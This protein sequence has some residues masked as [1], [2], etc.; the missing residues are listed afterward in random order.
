MPR[1]IYM[2]F[3][4]WV[5]NR[6]MYADG[7]YNSLIHDKDGHIP[8]PLLMFTCTA[9]GH[10][11]LECQKNQGV[12]P[13]ASKS[14]L[15]VERPDRSNYFNHN[16]DGGKIGSFCTVTGRELL[17]TPGVADTYTFLMNT[18]NTLLESYQQR[19]YNNSLATVKLQ[20]PQAENPMPAVVIS[21]EA[22]R[23]DNAILLDD[24]ASKVALE[25]PEIGG[26]DPNFP[27]DNNCTGDE[28]HFAMPG[29]SSIYEDD[30]DECEV[31]DGIPSANHQQRP[32]TDLERFDLV[33]SAVN[34]YEGEDGNNGDADGDEY[35]DVE[36]EASQVDDGSTQD[37]DERH[38]TR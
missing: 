24:L 1:F 25:E 27:I 18:L 28:H 3:Y 2:K 21:E 8:S 5:N 14:K 30:G 33:T 26:T 11:L 6:G 31:C 37:V 38:G 35:A 34:G 10:A 16:N 36:K 12:H 7:F 4:A 32:T 13:K 22:A 17:I 9:L 20:I 19:V 23:V 15:K 29:G